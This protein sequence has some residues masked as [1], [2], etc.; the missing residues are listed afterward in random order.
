[1]NSCVARQ[2]IFNSDLDVYG[3]ELLYRTSQTSEAYDGLDPDMASTET[4]TFSF[5]DVGIHKMTGNRKA[6]INFTEKLLLND[7]ATLLPKEVLVIEILE[8]VP[9]TSD[10]VRALRNLKNLGYTLSLDDFKYS[11]EYKPFLELADIV[12]IDFL[13]TSLAEINRT[14]HIITSTYKVHLLAEKIETY[15]MFKTAKEM[16]FVYFQGYF[17]SRPE[18]LSKKRLT[19]LRVTQLQLIR[20]AMDPNVDYGKLAA[21]I[22]NDVVLSYRILKLVNSAYYGLRYTVKNIRHALA[23]LGIKSIRKFVTMMTISQIVDEKPEELMR[24]SLIRGHFLEALAPLVNMRKQQENLFMLGLFSLMDV[25]ADIP[26]AEIIEE[27]QLSEEIAIPLMTQAGVP[28]ELLS[29][30]QNYEQGNWDQ[31]LMIAKK[32][33][34]PTSVVMRI[35]IDSVEWA[36]EILEF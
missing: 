16:G 23:I 30:I 36:S 29:I 12:K 28:G 9:P 31:A 18:M 1:M 14:V 32:Y 4:I 27:T 21:I 20:S 19:P 22:K 13:N 33:D 17:F 15:D 3:Y 6:F 35:Y 8:D 7:I 25:I 10:V 26:M 2:P 5:N 24:M 34:L 11:P